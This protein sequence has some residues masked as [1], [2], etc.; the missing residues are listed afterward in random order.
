M[1]NWKERIRTWL[2]NW[3]KELLEKISE[4]MHLIDILEESE[5]LE[6]FKEKAI[7]YTNSLTW[8][9]EDVLTALDVMLMEIEKGNDNG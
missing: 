9:K 3:E 4:F 1:K 2:Q 7:R 5:T 8:F 6:E